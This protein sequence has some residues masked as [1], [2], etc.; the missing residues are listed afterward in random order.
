M[1]VSPLIPIQNREGLF[2][3]VSA[4]VAKK[5]RDGYMKVL[6]RGDDVVVET[7]TRARVNL[8][9]FGEYRVVLIGIDQNNR[10]TLG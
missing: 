5:L 3:V 2:V 8:L 9:C 1:I 4:E 6:V 10:L 7:I